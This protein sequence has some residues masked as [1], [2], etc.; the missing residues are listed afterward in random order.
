MAVKIRWLLA[1]A[2]L[3]AGLA[4]PA[5]GQQDSLTPEQRK[6][7]SEALLRVQARQRTAEGERCLAKL[8]DPRD[9][10]NKYVHMESLRALNLPAAEGVPVYLGLLDSPA[11]VVKQGALFALGEYGPQARPAVPRILELFKDPA[12][13]WYV[14]PEAARALG[15]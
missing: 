11:D 10:S 2:V 12:R 4:R 9:S 5:P 8:A 1:S 3:A 14:A 6:Q 7:I 13:K 15:K